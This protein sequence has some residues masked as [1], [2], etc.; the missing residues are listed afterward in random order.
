MSTLSTTV[1]SRQNGV[2]VTQV[3]IVHTKGD[4]LVI[5]YDMTPDSGTPDVPT[6]AQ[7]NIK[8]IPSGSAV[9]TASAS[10]T[11]NTTSYNVRAVI[12]DSDLEGK[13]YF[14][15]IETHSTQPVTITPLFGILEVVDR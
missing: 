2:T 3:N 6:A 11:D 15:A 10:V 13:Y 7:V 5:D 9:A 14:E 1:T 12:N 4:T 8:N